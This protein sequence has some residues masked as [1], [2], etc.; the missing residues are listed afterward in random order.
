MQGGGRLRP[1]LTLAVS[2]ACGDHNPWLAE[3]VAASVELMHCASL[4][5]DDLPCF[6]D[7]DTRR[8]LPSI[9]RAYG[10]PIAVLV[11]DELIVLG[12]EVLARSG[13]ARKTAQLV[14]IMAK[15][16]RSPR[17][18]IAGQAWE[19][20]TTVPAD[21]YRRAKTAA[22][23]EAA[24]CGGA[25]A[26]GVDPMPW[27]PFGTKIG[28]A[29]QVADDI[30]DVQAAPWVVG[31][32]VGQDEVNDRPNAVAMLGLGQAHELLR[33]HLEEA[34]SIIPACESRA[35]VETWV[36][37]VSDRIHQALQTSEGQRK[38]G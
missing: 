13:D 1:S 19:S 9:H 37:Q 30:M 38:V 21:L 16:L 10:E 29:Y 33:R 28:E 11:G 24:A 12:F 25:A 6:D 3:D 18:I 2:A 20:E 31:K 17:G 35:P 36:G 32:P 27:R 15:A 8:G 23:F 4:V 34:E 7:A 22:L 26:A 5:H 14:S